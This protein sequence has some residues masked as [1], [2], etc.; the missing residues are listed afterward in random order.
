LALDDAVIEVKGSTSHRAVYSTHSLLRP[1]QHTPSFPL[2]LFDPKGKRG[3]EFRGVAVRDHR[4]DGA[5]RVGAGDRAM[6]DSLG[7]QALSC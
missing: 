1:Y 4:R 2:L 3:R 7:R 5:W 6:M